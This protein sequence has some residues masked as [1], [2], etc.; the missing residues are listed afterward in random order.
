MFA[1]FI[2]FRL[3]LIASLVFILGYIFGGFS[4]SVRLT[5]ITKVAAIVLVVTFVWANLAFFRFGGWRYGNF[6]C[7]DRLEHR[8]HTDS[9][10]SR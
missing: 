2:L 9:T 3:L 8:V 10:T 4:R 7:N 5:R 6:N 1:L